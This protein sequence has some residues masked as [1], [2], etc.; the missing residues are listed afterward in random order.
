MRDRWATRAL[1]IAAILEHQAEQGEEADGRELS[2]RRVPDDH[3]LALDDD[4]LHHVKQTPP[5]Q[6]Q[7][8]AGEQR[9]QDVSPEEAA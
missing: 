4:G 5:R 8:E 2:P 1:P 9:R 3:Q 6:A 7:G